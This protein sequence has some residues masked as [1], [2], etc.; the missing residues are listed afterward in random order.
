MLTLTLL[1]KLT[2][3][4]ALVAAATLA[5]RRWGARVGG[6]LVAFP[7][8]AGPILLFFAVEQGPVFTAQAAMGTVVGLSS[9][10]AFIAVYM[11]CA[12]RCGWAG[13]FGWAMASYAGCTALLS[14]LPVVWYTALPLAWVTLFVAHRFAPRVDPARTSTAPPRFELM[15]RMAA[16][17]VLVLSV[18]TLAGAMG[19]HLS[20][21]VSVF[22]VATAVMAV[23]THRHDGAGVAIRLLRG[24]LIGLYTFSLFCLTVALLVARLGAW[25]AFT[26]ALAVSV[27][28]QVVVLTWPLLRQCLIGMTE[29]HRA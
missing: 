29:R 25:R 20:G 7:L 4:P 24:L 1:L 22:P 9:I 17:A 21:L 14:V 12:H 3:A 5:T 8:V 16:T 13:A 28:A 27:S 18:T 26:L 11:H 23:F 19:P 15:I 2:L 10:S 6:V